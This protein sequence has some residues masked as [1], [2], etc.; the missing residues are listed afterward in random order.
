MNMQY[1]SENFPDQERLLD[2]QE[3]NIFIK[4][5]FKRELVKKNEFL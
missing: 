4:Q 1:Q 5:H 2:E 3:A